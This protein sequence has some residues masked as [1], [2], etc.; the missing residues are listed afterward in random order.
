MKHLFQNQYKGGIQ[1]FLLALF[2]ALLLTACG[3]GG[4]SPGGTGSGTTNPTDSTAAADAKV[5]SVVIQLAAN[6]M[7]SVNGSVAVTVVARDKNN[8]AVP[9]A[10]VG[11]SVSSGTI[12]FAS[13][14]HKTDTNGQVQATLTSPGDSSLR[15]IQIQ[16]AV[17]SVLSTLST[18]TVVAPNTTPEQRVAS[19]VLTTSSDT[20]P[21]IDGSIKVTA[22]AR[23]INNNIVTDAAVTLKADNDGTLTIVNPNSKT[24]K[25][26]QIIATLTSPG[27]A[28]PRV[29]NLSAKVGNISANKQVSVVLAQLKQLQLTASSGSLDSSGAAGTEV[30]ITAVVKDSGNNV[31]K[32]V[33]VDLSA[34]SGTLSLGTRVTDVNGTVVEKLSTAGNPNKRDIKVTASIP[35]ATKE[36][37]VQVSGTKLTILAGESASVGRASRLSAVLT[38]S[39]GRP[40][41]GQTVAFSAARNVSG[42]KAVGTGNTSS[43]VTD[44]QGQIQVDFTPV[45]APS[46]V[47]TFTALGVSE[48]KT[49]VISSLNFSVQAQSGNTRLTQANINT[50][51]RFVATVTGGSG[52]VSMSSSR[53]TVYSDAACTS[54][55]FS[56]MDLNESGTATAY[57]SANSPGVAT[58]VATLQ[59]T[60]ATATSELEFVA[61]L[62]TTPNIKLQA[63]PG[64]VGS[65]RQTTLKAV[66][67][68]GTLQ[69]NLVKDAFVVFSI[70]SDPSGGT[71]VQP[72]VVKTGSDGSATVVYTGG[73]VS[74]ALNG[75]TLKALIQGVPESVNNP[76]TVKLTVSGQPLF[77][78]AGTGNTVASPSTANYA[79][80][81]IVYVT[82]ATGN[83]VNNATVTASVRPRL[84]KK[85]RLIRSEIFNNV[86]YPDWHVPVSPLAA[87]YTCNNEDR[88][89][90]GILDEAED[91]NGNGRL[92]PG[93]PVNVTGAQTT[94][95]SGTAVV[96][97]SYPKD[98]ALWTYVD[99]TIRARVAGSE[100]I[101]TAYVGLPGPG[102][103]YSATVPSPPG[104]ISPY[105]VNPCTIAD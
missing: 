33:K 73:P 27:S 31:L 61:P 74:T 98:R 90:N 81:Y 8:N 2:W 83:A 44:S 36:L 19:L 95:A 32:D 94:T 37:I 26:G 49:I 34:D 35:G 21:T 56:A 67:R 64:T 3:G 103:D 71:M 96:T 38:D 29:I 75:V 97:L 70:V 80:D 87:V 28:A 39:N 45:G 60:Q 55:L 57:V 100:A 93:I 68:D 10:K 65:G 1:G 42:L 53:G 4:G 5:T 86:A 13:T 12:T 24:D 105:G 43:A 101:Y 51:I 89:F 63:D 48:S 52:K 91:D 6:T 22:I 40:L 30:T 11:L 66:V 20:M 16:A 23:D 18:V 99:L 58:L 14:D 41:S 82:D 84:Y 88:N 62:G 92:D 50:C 7:E 9:G 17:G 69:N 79:I 59:S 54:P 78:S 72:T 77:I 25:D 46:D 104:E 47:I 15:V 76:A 85:G 102:A